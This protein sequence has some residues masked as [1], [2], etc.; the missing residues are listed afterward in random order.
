MMTA[1]LVVVGHDHSC[2]INGGQTRCNNDAWTLFVMYISDII[3][4]IIDILVTSHAPRSH[5][6]LISEQQWRASL[7]IATMMIGVRTSKM[8]MLTEMIPN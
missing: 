8:E 5:A 2:R 3:V 1:P 4:I 6:K 7:C